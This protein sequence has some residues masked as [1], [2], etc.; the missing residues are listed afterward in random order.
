MKGGGGRGRV[1][2]RIKTA[3]AAVP[4]GRC[5]IERRRRRHNT[6]EVRAYVCL[7]AAL[8][9]RHHW[10]LRRHFA[11]LLDLLRPQRGRGHGSRNFLSSHRRAARCPRCGISALMD[12]RGTGANREGIVHIRLMILP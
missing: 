7:L 1:I 4:T 11:A 6:V 8:R 9:R 5:G 10:H 12:G 3:N 2:S